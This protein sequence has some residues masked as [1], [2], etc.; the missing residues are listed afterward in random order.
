MKIKIKDFNGIFTNNDENDNRLEYCKES[1]NFLH[2]RGFLELD[3]RGLEEETDMPDPTGDF[4][5]YTWIWETGIY[6]TL[7]SD[8]LSTKDIPVPSKHNVLVLIAKT[9]VGDMDH[10]LIYMKDITESSIWYEMSNKGNYVKVNGI[11]IID[12]VNHEDSAFDRSVFSTSVE[13]TVH[14]QVE[15]GRLK[16]YFPHDTFWLGKLDRKIWIPD[17]KHRW[18]VTVNGDTTYPNFDYEDDY[19]YLDR[20][21]EDWNFNKQKVQILNQ[22]NIDQVPWGPFSPVGGLTVAKGAPESKENRRTGLMYKMN[23][24]TEQT[25]IVGARDINV[26]GPHDMKIRAEAVW[27]TLRCFRTSLTSSD[28]FP[29]KNPL[30]HFPANPEIWLFWIDATRTDIN[31]IIDEDIETLDYPNIYLTFLPHGQDTFRLRNEGDVTLLPSYAEHAAGDGKVYMNSVSTTVPESFW[32]ISLEDFL[33]EDWEYGGDQDVE[34]IGWSTTEDKFSI[35]VTAVVDEREEFPIGA[36]NYVVEP[37]DKYVITISDIIIPWDINKRI[38]RMRFYHKLKSTTDYEMVK[39]FDLLSADASIEQ[40]D[41][42]TDV[43]DGKFLAANTG[44]LWDYYDHPADYKIM[45]GW[46]DFVTESGISIGISSNDEVAIYHSTYGGGALMPD[47]VYDDN[48]LPITGVSELTAV[49]NVDGRLMA[50]SP[51]TSY[52]IQAQ[53]MAGVIAFRFED[54]VEVGVKDKNDVASIQGG[55]LVHTQ[56]G[57]YI[58]NGYETKSISE[59]ID[60]IIRDNYSTGRVYYNRYKHEVY[61]KPTQAEDL[62]RF[63]LVDSVWEHLDKTVTY[64]DQRNK[65]IEVE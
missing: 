3:P 40:F 44:F 11:P 47:L 29:V 28:G 55:V 8:I 57:I 33:D 35:I 6:T 43:Y 2:K 16:I 46:K 51:H 14:F 60:D 56:H 27:S 17:D 12:I 59:P 62:F 24:N 63:R 34:G 4:P 48:R 42:S 7:T 32:S 54:T 37:D 58:S 52:V 25:H 41:I 26:G 1:E 53:E 49:A 31:I 13:G 65:Y 23:L 9:T 22:D 38:T 61:Y 64:Q 20:I 39:D 18:G 30:L 15:D 50:F 5:A 45:S 36:Y 21:C 10:R 19:W